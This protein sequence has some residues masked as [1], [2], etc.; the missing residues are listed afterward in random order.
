MF[1]LPTLLKRVEDVLDFTTISNQCLF[2]FDQRR[3]NSFPV[4]LIKI[5]LLDWIESNMKALNLPVDHP[6]SSVYRFL[7]SL[8]F[9]YD[10]I[11]KQKSIVLSPIDLSHCGPYV[12]SFLLHILINDDFS[13]SYDQF[14]SDYL[15]RLDH[16]HGRLKNFQIHLE[17]FRDL[18]NNV[19]DAMRYYTQ[20]YTLEL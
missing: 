9:C 16:L 3:M 2:T 15:D 12:F 18:F 1:I 10:A 5:R 17:R 14:F 8:Y 6:E 20:T 7:E 13:V 11:S 4:D 19:Y